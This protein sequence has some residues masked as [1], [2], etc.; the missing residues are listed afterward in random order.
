MGWRIGLRRVG[1]ALEEAWRRAHVIPYF[2]TIPN[3]FY[4]SQ[5][6]ER[7]RQLKKIPD[8]DMYIEDD[9]VKEIRKF[10]KG[11]INFVQFVSYHFY[12]SNYV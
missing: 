7:N 12:C 3:L 11:Y 9:A 10:V 6:V 5:E 4:I 1:D 2:L 8:I